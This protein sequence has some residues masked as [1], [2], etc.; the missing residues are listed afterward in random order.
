MPK[1]IPCTRELIASGGPGLFLLGRV[2]DRLPELIKAYGGKVQLIYLDPPFGTGELFRMRIGGAFVQRPAYTDALPPD[3]YLEFM[4][5]VLEGCRELLAPSGSLYLH[6]DYRMAAPLRMMLDE[7]FGA[8][9]LMNEIVWAYQSGGRSTAHFSR[10]HDIILFYRKSRD[11]FFDMEAVGIPRG[12]ER[13]NHMKRF[14]DDKGRVCY[15]IRSGGKLYTYREDSL[16]YPSDVWTDIEHLHQ[17]D[18]ERTGYATQKPEALLKRI[19]LASSREGD[20]VADFFSGSGTTAAVASRTGR[21]FLACDS[22]NYALYALRKRQCAQYNTMN[23]LNDAQP[24]ELQFPAWIPDAQIDASFRRE[25]GYWSCTVNTYS[26]EGS[27]TALIYCALGSIYDGVFR[28]GAYAYTPAMPL[29]LHIPACEHGVPV[30]QTMDVDGRQSFF[31]L[32]E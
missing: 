28:A 30:L 1:A 32:D 25:G 18:P 9:N 12:P 11:V 7:L 21:R 16:V 14:V 13:R 20:I 2:E 5:T 26:A 10:K 22:S 31:A 24:L 17:R 27:R 19:L 23:F 3:Q 29:I 8:K 15:S 6:V 4:R